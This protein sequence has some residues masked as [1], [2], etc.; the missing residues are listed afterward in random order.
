MSSQHPQ[1]EPTR[2]LPQ[3]QQYGQQQPYGRPQDQHRTGRVPQPRQLPPLTSGI[4]ADRI[5]AGALIALGLFCTFVFAHN[6]WT[7]PDALSDLAVSRLGFPDF[8]LPAWVDV[9]CAGA[10]IGIVILF[11]GSV[12]GA[13]QLM[14][15][16]KKSFGVPLI[17]G[18]VGVIAIPIVTFIVISTVPDLMGQLG[19]PGVLGELIGIMYA[20]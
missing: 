9:L 4:I 3:T 14:R 12:F 13:V 8:W 1:H 2:R 18:V 11:A 19:A 17:A 6:L 16:R 7:L 15:S 5:V 20:P 10:A